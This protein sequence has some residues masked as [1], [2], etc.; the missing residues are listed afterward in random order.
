MIIKKIQAK[1][2]EAPQF[3]VFSKSKIMPNVG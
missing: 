2:L 3:L 1:N